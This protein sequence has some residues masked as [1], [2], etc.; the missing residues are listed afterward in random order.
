[1]E[2]EAAVAINQEAPAVDVSTLSPSQGKA[3][4]TSSGT[5]WKAHSR[6]WESRARENA[7]EVDRLKQELK[8]MESQRANEDQTNQLSALQA[9]VASLQSALAEEKFEGIFNAAISAAGAPHLAALKDELN[10]DSFRTEDGSWDSEKLNSFVA[11]L[12]PAAVAPN[13][14][15]APGLPQNFSQVTSASV[16]DEEATARRLADQMIK[17]L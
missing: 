6:T 10:R 15:S 9:Q 17:K 11:S 14:P 5:D 1:M 7:A 16:K 3:E 13:A 2:N 12:A 8:D 4:D